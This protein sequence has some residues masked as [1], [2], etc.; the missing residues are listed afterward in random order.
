MAQQTVKDIISETYQVEINPGKSI[1]ISANQYGYNTDVS[2]NVG[3]QAV[4]DSYNL[5]Y[6]GTII[7]I[8]EKTV[9]IKPKYSNGN[10]RMKLQEFCWRNYN[11]NA[12]QIA[13]ENYETSMC[14]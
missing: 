1:R 8:T 5:I 7:K 9:T 3:D 2:F 6:L 11:F 14:I 4:Y 13:K 10:K 12:E